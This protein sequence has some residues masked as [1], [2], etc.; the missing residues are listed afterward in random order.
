MNPIVGRRSW[1]LV[2]AATVLISSAARAQTPP[3]GDEDRIRLAE[4]FALAEDVQNCVWRDW[5]SAPF[6]VLLVAGEHEYLVRHPA[7]SDDFTSLGY[8]SLLNSEVFARKRVFSP[9][10][11][12]TFPAVGGIPSVVI[13]QPEFTGKSSTLWALTALHE[14]FH[15]LQYSQPDY[16]EAVN[17]LD[18]SGG[19][20]TGMWMLNY[21]FPYEDAEVVAGLNGYGEALRRALSA[22]HTGRADSVFSQV[23]RARERLREAL[24]EKD[25]RYLSFQLWQEGVARYTEYRVAQVAAERHAPLPAFERLDDY[26][27]YAEAADSLRRTLAAELEHLDIRSWKRAAFYPLGAAHALLLDIMRPEWAAF[28]LED[29]FSL[30]RR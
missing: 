20:E 4:S 2:C 19:D 10:L 21:P 29:K 16:Y 17:A 28:Y 15:Q 22:A 24:S 26:V 7:P 8:D 12:A 30:Q 13:G 9:E 11:L 14:H 25:D 23:T 18:L 5:S 1:Q 3:L 27:P 6:A